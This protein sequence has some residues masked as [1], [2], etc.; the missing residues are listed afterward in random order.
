[1]DSDIRNIR[2]VC[3]YGAYGNADAVGFW[4]YGKRKDGRTVACK[5]KQTADGGLI[6]WSEYFV[7]DECVCDST[8]LTPLEWENIRKL[9]S[10]QQ[11]L[12]CNKILDGRKS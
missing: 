6:V 11:K 12:A 10:Y 7:G 2:Q 4:I 1:M 8:E 3:K 9:D 5:S